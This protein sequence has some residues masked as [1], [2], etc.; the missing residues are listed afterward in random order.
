MN[1]K[2]HS[3]LCSIRSKVDGTHLYED[4]AFI[5]KAGQKFEIECLHALG[6]HYLVDIW[7]KNKLNIIYLALSFNHT[8]FL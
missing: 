3:L 8:K 6:D 4:V 2:D 7:L 1:E 5:S